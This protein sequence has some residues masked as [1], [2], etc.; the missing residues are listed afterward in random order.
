MAQSDTGILHDLTAFQRDM[1]A[2]VAQLS[3]GE[4]PHGLAIKEEIQTMY[5]GKEVHHGRLYPNLDRLVQMGLVEKG[6]KDKRTNSYTIT[7]RG[8]REAQADLQRR[9]EA[10][11]SDE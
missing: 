8:R 11:E 4:P 5:D 1:L 7:A 6:V 2:A 3:G 10:L 9:R